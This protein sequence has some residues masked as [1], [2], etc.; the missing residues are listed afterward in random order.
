MGGT[1]RR[2]MPGAVFGAHGAARLYFFRHRQ[3]PGIPADGNAGIRFS[4]LLS[5]FR[6][7]PVRHFG[8]G[9]RH[10]DGTAAP[11][12]DK[13]HRRSTQADRGPGLYAGPLHRAC[14]HRPPGGPAAHQLCR[15]DPAVPAASWGDTA[16]ISAYEAHGIRLS[17]AAQHE[18]ISDAVGMYDAASFCRLFKKI[19]ALTPSEYRTQNRPLPRRAGNSGEEKTSP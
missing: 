6:R 12:R 13:A 9:I 15:P 2:H 11:G 16:E 19:C 3:S 7:Q 10:S 17:A 4:L 1:V 18:Q 8:P 5:P 14:V